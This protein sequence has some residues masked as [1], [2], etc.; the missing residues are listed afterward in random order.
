MGDCRECANCYW[1]DKCDCA[2]KCDDYTPMDSEE[3]ILY[4]QKV[5]AENAE[6]YEIEIKEFQ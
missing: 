3:D 4:Y 1:A 2:Y 6:E 5:L